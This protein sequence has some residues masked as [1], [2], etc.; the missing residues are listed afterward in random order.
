[1]PGPSPRKSFLNNR[2]PL[3]WLV[4][5]I[6]GCGVSL[7]FAFRKP[8]VIVESK[9]GDCVSFMKQIRLNRFNLIHPLLLTDLEVEDS[10]L[11]TLKHRVEELIEARKQNH[12]IT[13]ASVY[14]RSL[15]DGGWFAINPEETYIPASLQK[16]GI[17]MSYLKEVEHNPALLDYKIKFESHFSNLPK[18]NIKD[19]SLEEHQFYTVKDLLHYMIAFSD[20]DALNL[21]YKNMNNTTYN[22]LYTDIGLEV[23]NLERDD[24]T[25]SVKNFARFFRMLYSAT[26]LSNDLSEMGLELL[27]QSTYRNGICRNLD[28]KIVVAHKFGERAYG[29]EKQLHEFAIVYANNQPYLLGIMT[30]GN[31]NIPLSDVLSEIS[32]LVYTGMLP[33]A[34]V[35]A[36]S[37]NKVSRY[38]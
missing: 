14:V 35:S 12:A 22:N 21:L 36:G 31:D 6:V 19:F 15:N 23:P 3:Y 18:Q 16:V 34:Y 27:A 28:P 29:V 13:S 2:V 25:V 4:L 17:M 24:Y 33:L 30:K 7:F 10:R 1:M 8:K 37:G 20:N 9:P 5:V 32:D 26:Y 38:N 11:Q